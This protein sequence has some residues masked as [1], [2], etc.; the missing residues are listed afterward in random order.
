MTALNAGLKGLSRIL[1]PLGGTVVGRYGH[2][3]YGLSAQA[4]L[5]PGLYELTR[6]GHLRP[7]S[8]EHHL[9]WTEVIR[10]RNRVAD[11]LRAARDLADRTTAAI[12]S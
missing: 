12:G 1:V 11:G 6:L 2:D 8:E 5:L 7:G 10:Q 3:P 9:V 4:T